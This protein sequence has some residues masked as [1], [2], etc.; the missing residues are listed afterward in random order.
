M[1]TLLNKGKLTVFNPEVN[2]NLVQHIPH[3]HRPR[4]RNHDKPQIRWCLV[5][6]ELVLARPVGDEGVVVAAELTDHVAKG[7]DGSEDEFG[8]IAGGGG[9]RRGT[10][11]VRGE[12]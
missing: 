11:G 1:K 10:G 3:T 8:V 7:E 6:V 9:A 5:V 4:I 12:P 2:V